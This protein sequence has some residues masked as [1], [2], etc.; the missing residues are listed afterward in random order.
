MKKMIEENNVFLVI[1]VI[2]LIIIIGI[3]LS[4]PAYETFGYDLGQTSY[5]CNNTNANFLRIIIFKE[6]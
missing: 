3:V 4:L 5:G 1:L 6:C 2:A